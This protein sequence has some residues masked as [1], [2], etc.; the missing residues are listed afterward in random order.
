MSRDFHTREAQ[1]IAMDVR[2][3]EELHMLKE[4]IVPEAGYGL[5]FE[6]ASAAAL[7]KSMKAHSEPLAR[8]GKVA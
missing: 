8:K 7:M 5:S 3:L 2:A 1:F 6:G 4:R